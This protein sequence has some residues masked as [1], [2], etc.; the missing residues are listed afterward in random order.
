[1]KQHTHTGRLSNAGL[2]ETPQI[3][4]HWCVLDSAVYFIR[5]EATGRECMMWGDVEPDSISLDPRN[6]EVW[7]LA[8][9]KFAEGKLSTVFIECSYTGEQ[10]DA[11]LYGHLS[12]AHLMRELRTLKDEVVAV[13]PVL[14]STRLK[15]LKIVVTHVKDVMADGRDC[16]KEVEAELKA[17]ETKEGLGVSFL[18]AKRGMGVYF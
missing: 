11:A 5:D 14:A 13:A 18:M 6:R 2:P 10:A 17:L 4:S 9:R 8:A 1:M 7:A 16:V 15:G 12:P 3:R